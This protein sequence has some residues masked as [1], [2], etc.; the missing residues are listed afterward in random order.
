VRN[1]RVHVLIDERLVVPG[2]R[3]GEGLQI[4]ERALWK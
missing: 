2:P 4:I 3:I 1:K